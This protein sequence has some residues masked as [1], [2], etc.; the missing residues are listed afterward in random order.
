MTRTPTIFLDVLSVPRV[1]VGLFACPVKYFEQGQWN[2]KV[3]L[4]AVS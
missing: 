2:R 3:D 4:G 1:A